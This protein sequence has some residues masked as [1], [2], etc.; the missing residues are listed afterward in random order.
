M[1]FIRTNDGEINVDRIIRA[2]ERERAE[3]KGPNT[4]I[5]Y[6]EGGERHHTMAYLRDGLAVP[7]QPL[8]PASP[9][10]YVVQVVGPD[11]FA[12]LRVPV[13]AWRIDNFHALPVAAGDDVT[14]DQNE[15]GILC[16]D[17]RV[18][19]IEDGTYDNQDEYLREMTER[20]RA[21]QVRA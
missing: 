5:V 6:E 4:T 12:L 19:A 20:L 17:G 1:K 10:F 8:V 14:Y 2:V 16:P 18:V 7:T 15:W 11:P 13:I 21:R 9:G 3:G